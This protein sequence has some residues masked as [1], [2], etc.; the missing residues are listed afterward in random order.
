MTH[1]SALLWAVVVLGTAAGFAQ[2]IIQVL[3]LP[4]TSYYNLA[5]GLAADTSGLYLSSNSSDATLGRRIMKLSFSGVPLDSVSAPTG[6]AESQG[7]TRDNAGN[8][9]F[10]RRYTSTCTIM[11]ISP[12]GAL[13][14]SLRIPRYVGGLTWDG[15]YI[16]FSVY[17][18]NT[19]A[20]LV[21]VDFTTKTLLDTILVP[22]RQPYGV[23]WDGT[24]LYYVENG[25]DGD[26]RGMFRVNPATGD[27][28]GFI[29]EPI[30]PSGTSPRDCAWDGR[31]MWLLAEPVGSNTGR[32]LYKYDLGGGGTAD[33]NILPT[34]I[35]FGTHRI[36]QVYV[37]SVT[38][39]N[40]G[41]ATLTVDSVVFPGGAFSTAFAA[42]VQ[43]QAAR[44]ARMGIRWAPTVYGQDSSRFLVYARDPDEPVSTIRVSG[45]ASYGDPVMSLPASYD[46]GTRRTGTSSSWKMVIQN[47]GG[48]PLIISSMTTSLSAYRLDSL[49]FPLAIDSMRSKTFRVWFEPAAATTYADSL[50]ITSNASNGSLMKVALT[51]AGT[52]APVAL[53]SPFWTYTV[54]DH[55]VSNTGRLVKA[56]RAISDITGDGKPDVVVSTENYWTM[57]LNGNAST[58]NDSLWA[59]N[60]FISNYSAGS[61]GTTGDYSH[62]KALD[63]ASDLNGD[64]VKDIVIGTG[65]GNE[66]VYAIDGRTGRMIW[67]FGTDHPD[68]FSLGDITAVDVSTDYTGDGKP[69]VIAAAAAT[70]SGGVGG[71][72]SAYLF[73]GTNGQIIWQAPLPGFTH[74]VTAIGDISGDGLPDVI[75]AVGEPSYKMT[76][77][78]GLN[79]ALLWDFTVT[80]ASGGGKEVMAFPVTGQS[81]DVI[82]GAFWGP[83]YRVDG[84]SGT[85]VW[86]HTTGSGVMQLK[87]LRDVTGDG[88]DEI[89]AALLGG[90]ALCLNGA[91]GATVWSLPTGNTMGITPVPD[92]NGDGID[93]VAIA[94]QDQGALI[95]RGN[96]GQQ[97]ALYTGFGSNECRE[98]A[99]VPDIDGNGSWEIIAGS[100]YGQI[101]LIS[102]GSGATFIETK[103]TAPSE[104]TLSQ[105]YPNPFNPST[106]IKIGL[107]ISTDF[108]LDIFDIL[109]RKVKSFV[110]DRVPAGTHTVEWDGTMQDGSGASSGVYFYRMT[111]G[112]RSLTHRM[113]L[114]K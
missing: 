86:S 56:V 57:A 10:V 112:D 71:R 25:F 105:N 67:T 69:D 76:A 97:L 72:R 50:R 31:Y 43:I 95:V 44:S 21:K 35:N 41:T 23:D 73:N 37:D 27:T 108:S 114:L 51:G 96:N 98:I 75:G 87:R 8:F 60:T 88:V 85:Q 42:P 103:P 101:A 110:Y 74:G 80:S 15:A 46:Y 58:T 1:R 22:T 82:L 78:N 61:I 2:S 38:I 53:G 26:V 92:L 109:G 7:L 17:Y 66:H 62:Q 48:G 39:Q 36:N 106:T 63:V 16:W 4:N 24:H 59:F 11:K 54:V 55:P 30:D 12:A 70:E 91:T 84:E 19:E 18:P 83:I 94:D 40:V 20:S 107:P 49:V 52:D 5:W 99:V 3:P 93:E 100:K 33:I 34:S 47:Q 89:L 65:G 104:F 64:G 90:G 68:S 111:S 14:D 81:P 45:F 79:G 32:V 9:Y 13:L 102:G 77:F 28:A 29:P 6:I 113:L